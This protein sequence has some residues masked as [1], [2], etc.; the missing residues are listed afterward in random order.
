MLCAVV[1]RAVMRSSGKSVEQ[2]NDYRLFCREPPLDTSKSL[3]TNDVTRIMLSVGAICDDILLHCARRDTCATHRN[4]PSFGRDVVSLR[5]EVTALGLL[6]SLSTDTHAA[7]NHF[8]RDPSRPARVGSSSTTDMHVKD[9]DVSHPG[10]YAL[11]A[12]QR[13]AV[14]S[15]HM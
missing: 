6:P 1:V 2:R 15:T 4:T 12:S 8:L 5:T 7:S 14:Q 11:D 3:P 10:H 9:L 13:T